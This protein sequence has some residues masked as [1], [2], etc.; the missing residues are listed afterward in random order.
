MDQLAAGNRGGAERRDREG[1]ARVRIAVSPPDR[2]VHAASV[3]HAA[4]IIE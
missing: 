2:Q 3:R 4:A 1:E